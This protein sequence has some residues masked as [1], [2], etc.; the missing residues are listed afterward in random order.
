VS[1]PRAPEQHGGRDT[2]VKGQRLVIKASTRRYRDEGVVPAAA[3]STPCAAVTPST[4]F[5]KQFRSRFPQLKT[6]NGLTATTKSEPA[7]P[8]HVRRLEPAT[9]LTTMGF[10]SG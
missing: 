10:L 6:W 4:A 8:G 2:L 1:T 5:R 7:A 9:G 3:C